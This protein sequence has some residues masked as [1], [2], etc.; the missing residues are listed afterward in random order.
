MFSSERKA[1]IDSVLCMQKKP[2][3]LNSAIYPGAKS[4]F[5]DFIGKFR[6]S[7][8][9]SLPVRPVLAANVF[10]TLSIWSAS[11]LKRKG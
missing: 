9:S 4:R 3:K 2:S 10:E 6:P 1:Y 7:G 5:D 8:L 11:I